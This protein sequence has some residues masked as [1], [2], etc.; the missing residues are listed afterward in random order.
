MSERLFNSDSFYK[1][2]NEEK[3]M[4]SRCLK[5][6]KLFLPPRAMCPDDYSGDME[7]TQFSGRGTLAAF[8]II[9]IGPSAMI[10]TG[11]DREHPYCSGIVELEEG[12]RISAQILDVD[13]YQPETIRI[14]MPLEAAFVQRGPGDNPQ[15]ALAFRPAVSS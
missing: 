3:L 15:K 11:Y 6:G 8:S 5:D 13:V 10:A 9:Y 2:L 12:V 4:G 7:W 14:G 1:F